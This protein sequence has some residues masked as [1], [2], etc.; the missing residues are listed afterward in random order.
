M[1]A[2][3]RPTP[4]TIA[5]DIAVRKCSPTKYR[6]GTSDG[7]AALVT[8]LAALVEDGHPDPV[9]AGREARAPHDVLDLDARCR[10]RARASPSSTPV[11][12]P[13]RSTPRRARSFDFTRMSGTPFVMTFGRALRPIGVFT[14]MTRGNT[15]PFRMW[16]TTCR[17]IGARERPGDL[18]GAR[19]RHRDRMGGCEFLRDL[20][21]RVAGADE[22]HAPRQQLV[23]AAVLPGVQLADVR[24]E[25]RR[26]RRDARHLVVRHR[27][28]HAA[29]G[30]G[31]VAAASD[32]GRRPSDASARRPASRCAPGVRRCARRA[33]GSRPWRPSTASR[34]GRPGSASRRGRRS[35]RA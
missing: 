7:H 16:T 9:E 5:D 14:D 31:L 33:R 35:G 32:E 26:E 25:L 28:D 12:R 8:R 18:T 11:T 21:R 19:P 34:R 23:G 4:C 24:A 2:A 30:E 13:A 17:L 29:S 10:R 22:E 6:P 3:S 15:K 1:R 20:G 27:H